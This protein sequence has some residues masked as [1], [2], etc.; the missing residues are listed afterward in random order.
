MS[1]KSEES[2]EKQELTEA[3][4]EEASGGLGRRNELDHIGAYSFYVENEGTSGAGPGAN[5]IRTEDASGAE[6][7]P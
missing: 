7:E 2:G 1:E 6:E 5:E 3:S 4:L